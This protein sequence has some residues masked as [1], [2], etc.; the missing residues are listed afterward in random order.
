MLCHTGPAQSRCLACSPGF[1]CIIEWGLALFE[2]LSPEF[3]TVGG[4]DMLPAASR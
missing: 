1:A 3:F 2:S 4:L